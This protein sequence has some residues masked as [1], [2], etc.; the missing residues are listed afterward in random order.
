MSA[1]PFY[2]L[3]ISLASCFMIVLLAACGSQGAAGST[4]TPASSTPTTTAIASGATPTKAPATPVTTTVPE[5]PTLTSCPA[6]GT[7]RA[8]V[9]APLALGNHANII[10]IVNQFQGQASSAGTL[11]RYDV[12]SGAKTEVVTLPNTL[13][14]DAQ[15]STDGQWVLF[16]ALANGQAKLQMIRMDGRGLQTL[17]CAAPAT[18]GVNYSSAIANI[19]WTTDQKTIAFENYTNRG[20]IVYLLKPQSG[21]LVTEFL[22]P[23][24]SVDYRPV[25]W[26]D[27]TRLYLRGL[28][29]D[30]PSFV[31]YL[32]D[33]SKGANQTFSSLKLIYDASSGCSCGDFD[34][35]YDGQHVDI[36]SYTTD[37][38][39]SGPG[40]G[41]VHGP[42]TVSTRPS[43]G[44]ASTTLLTSPNMAL[45]TI[46]VVSQ[47]TV[48][49]IVNN[50]GTG[51]GADTSHNGLWK[52]RADGTGLTRLTSVGGGVSAGPA[53]L[54]QYNQ[55]PWS[56]VSRDGGM[57]A[58]QQN[59]GNSNVSLLYGSL[60]G[61][62]PTTFASIADGTQLSIV[63]WTTM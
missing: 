56:N 8:A 13:I 20:N 27:N 23:Q 50:S 57:Y 5:P 21:N 49:L 7:A 43:T 48:L 10:Y 58:L 41:S 16:V 34:S 29:A 38:S 12:S 53:S 3:S 14:F 4:P 22:A 19:Q 11:K 52:M 31:F 6:N 63:G 26:L 54:N 60:N 25:T 44:G 46:R 2:R 28:N 30:A 32:L 61:G 36:V 39:P 33:T 42:S 45:T 18:S 15:V 37:P 9:M 59:G 40:I 55:Y 51:A 35:S 1:K 47:N 62:N 24:G 17:Y